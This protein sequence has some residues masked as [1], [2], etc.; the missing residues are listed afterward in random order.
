MSRKVKFNFFFVGKDYRTDKRLTSLKGPA[1]TNIDKY[2]KR[3]GK[4]VSRRKFNKFGI[5][6]KDMDVPDSHKSYD[7]IHD[8]VGSYRNII[9]RRPTKKEQK[10]INKARN[11]R[12]FWK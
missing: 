4:F 12:R 6:I 8:I 1:N 7:H 10:E 2:D 9:D 5:A 11:K 3:T